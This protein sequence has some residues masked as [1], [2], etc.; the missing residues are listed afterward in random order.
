MYFFWKPPQRFIAFVIYASVLT[1]HVIS[2][3]AAVLDDKGFINPS[4]MHEVLHAYQLNDILKAIQR[5]KRLHKH[6]TI[7]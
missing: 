2:A 3:Q 5:V 6:I 7:L 4:S 1:T